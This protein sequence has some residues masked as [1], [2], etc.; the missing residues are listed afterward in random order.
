ML[1][2][3]DG[4]L[5]SCS[6]DGTIRIWDIEEN[7][8]VKILDA[9]QNNLK[10]MAILPNGTLASGTNS[11]IFIWTRWNNFIKWKLINFYNNNIA[12]LSNNL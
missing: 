10:S 11:E 1:L 2:I 5:A 6:D 12:F 8:T 4:T 3:K 9:R 7:K